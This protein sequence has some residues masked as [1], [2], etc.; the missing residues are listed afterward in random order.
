MSAR[1]HSPLMRPKEGGDYRLA[2]LS[3]TPCSV[4]ERRPVWSSRPCWRP[5][6]S[7][8]RLK[9]RLETTA[10]L[11]RSS[12]VLPRGVSEAGKAHRLAAL[13]KGSEY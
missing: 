1:L 10:R 12:R 9:D 4:N 3:C 5:R 6:W 13:V 7:A 8:F 2:L 11:S